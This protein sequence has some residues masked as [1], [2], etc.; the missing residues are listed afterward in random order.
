MVQIFENGGHRITP[1]LPVNLQKVVK[2]LF[3]KM[4]RNIHGADSIGADV[5]IEEDD[6][7]EN[8]LKR[9]V[10]ALASSQRNTFGKTSASTMTKFLM[11]VICKIFVLFP[12]TTRRHVNFAGVQ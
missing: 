6:F 12:S 1:N 10:E 9:S 11:F 3:S 4:N 8:E 7:D 2:N 5:T